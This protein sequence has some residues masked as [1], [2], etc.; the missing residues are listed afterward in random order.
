MSYKLDKKVN[1]KLLKTALYSRLFPYHPIETEIA[2]LEQK[3]ADVS[4]AMKE[5]DE[6]ISMQKLQRNNLIS[7]QRRLEQEIDALR[8]GKK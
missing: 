8:N 3:Q 7:E 5:Y 4:N 1:H 6:P 2:Q